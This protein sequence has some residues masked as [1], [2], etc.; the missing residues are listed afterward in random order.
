MGTPLHGPD[1]VRRGIRR[2]FLVNG[3][4]VEAAMAIVGPVLD[5]YADEIARLTAACGE[6]EEEES[7]LGEPPPGALL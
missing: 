4:S 2:Q 5:W 3:P 6:S 1:A 7:I